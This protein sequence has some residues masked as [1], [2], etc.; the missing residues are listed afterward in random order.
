MEK[1]PISVHS[2]LRA[3]SNILFVGSISTQ[4]EEV[5]G[6]P[7]SG[8]DDNVNNTLLNICNYANIELK[9]CSLT[10]FVPFYVPDNK[11]LNKPNS[12]YI[13]FD[14]EIFQLCKENL[15]SIIRK[16][17]PNIVILLGDIATNCLFS[18]KE[19]DFF[20]QR[21]CW[22]ARG[23]VIWNKELNVKV[24]ATMHPEDIVKVPEYTHITVLD[25]IKYNKE[26]KTKYLSPKEKTQTIIIDTPSKFEN[27]YEFLK[28]LNVFSVDTETSGLNPRTDK[29]LS[30]GF[31]VGK[32]GDTH[33]RF[34]LPVYNDGESLYWSPKYSEEKF[35]NKLIHLFTEKK[36][37]TKVFFNAPFDLEFLKV[38]GI[39]ITENINDVMFDLR[40]WNENLN[41]SASCSLDLAARTFTDLGNYEKD[42]L[43]YINKN[44]GSKKKLKSYAA[45]PPSILW[46]YLGNDVDATLRTYNYI[47]PQLTKKQ[48]QLANEVLFPL[49]VR[50]ADIECLGNKIDLNK[51]E[52]A[53][54]IL[55]EK[56]EDL[57]N[58]IYALAGEQFN[59]N[60]PVQL[61][62]IL[63]KDLKLK[64][65]VKT[66]KGK[67]STGEKA[68]LSLKGKH[69]IVDCLLEYRGISKLLSTF[70]T[71]LDKFLSGD[72]V[73][74]QINLV[75]TLTGRTTSSNP[76]IQQIPREPKEIR[77][78]HIPEEDHIWIEADYE[79]AELFMMAFYAQDKVLLED[80]NTIEDFH[81]FI[82]KEVGITDKEKA[83]KEERIKAKAVAFGICIS[84]DSKIFQAPGIETSLK[85]LV[86]KII[87]IFD[88]IQFRTAHVFPTGEKQVYKV[89]CKD[90]ILK[91]SPEHRF[92]IRQENRLTWE[93]IK[94][95]NSFKQFQEND[96]YFA[97]LRNPPS[98]VVS[99]ED[100]KPKN[101]FNLFS[102]YKLNEDVTIEETLNFERMVDVNVLSYEHMFACEN[103]IVH[104]CYGA[105]SKSLAESTGL[106]PAVV[107]GVVNKFFQ[108]YPKTQEF[109]DRQRKLG[110]YG[111]YI[112]YLSG[113]KR[114]FLPPVT[115]SKVTHNLE[116][117][118][119]NSPIQGTVS[120]VVLNSIVK[121]LD[122]FEKE[123]IPARLMLILHDAGHYSV[124]KNYVEKACQ[125]IKEE[126]QKP[127]F[128]TPFSLP[129]ELLIGRYWGDQEAKII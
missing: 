21:K 59:I 83:T 14:S 105:A 119:I 71:G 101:L 111:G 90:K 87:P 106:P 52:E 88:G 123:K 68:L 80:L 92:L 95:L 12:P 97:V 126:M 70:V 11:N 38:F 75:G 48:Q 100:I 43:K 109:M 79:R 104:N 44:H 3:K 129:V 84:E 57:I 74:P 120:D 15:F 78:F 22:E 2:I 69:D 32:I 64:C 63:Y 46:E 1:L 28:P 122:R 77:N 20:F 112:E 73:F 108:R 31:G 24:A 49:A 128:N 72:R 27:F 19:G 60:S 62:D 36:E 54:K 76:N 47:W 121:I 5:Y 67:A 40:L 56:K 96:T 115:S 50:I 26:S 7:F 42:L 114:K 23:E 124:H 17:Q 45:I 113:R 65:S 117:K 34:V 102:Y 37:A 125:I 30:I 18:E 93:M 61:R 116:R 58:N 6:L 85:G 25:L 29:I 127:F 8:S 118:A 9:E 81:S 91:C 55:E 53:E 110:R 107:G 51:K 13:D 89:K 4:S 66:D 33:L 16:V 39:K 103:F 35:K 99:P 41:P 94:D 98:K 86:G 82:A 10:N